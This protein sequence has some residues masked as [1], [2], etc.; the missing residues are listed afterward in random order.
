MRVATRIA[1]TLILAGAGCTLLS[2]QTASSQVTESSAAS[3]TGG[4]RQ[5]SLTFDRKN[6]PVSHYRLAVSEDGS[7]TYEG[8]EVSPATAHGAAADQ[9][10]RPFQHHVRITPATTERVFNLADKLKH[11]DMNCESKAKN[12]ADMGSKTFRYEGPGN[13]GAACTYNYTEDKDVHAI[14]EIFQGIA[15]TLDQGRLLDR[16]HRFDRLGLD[17]AMTRLAMEVSS[18]DALEI[19]I[20]A[21]SLQSIAADTGVISR[22]R[23]RAMELLNQSGYG[24]PIS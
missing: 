3:N 23:N 11:F 10:A 8:D 20:I 16:L 5:V 21:P 19:G 12:I 1:A 9:T 7:A 24:K 6:V 13:T 22:V 15:E 17:A 2:A 14:T 4:K 18:G